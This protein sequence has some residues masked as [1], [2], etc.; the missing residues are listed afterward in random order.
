MALLLAAIGPLHLETEPVKARIKILTAMQRHVVESY[1][2]R[3]FAVKR[4]K[5]TF[6]I[7]DATWRFVNTIL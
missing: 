4:V 3:Y 7:N 2:S 5:A 1:V 6:D